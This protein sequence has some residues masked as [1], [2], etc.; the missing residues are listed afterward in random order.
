MLQ[1]VAEKHNW[2]KFISMQGFYNF[3]YREEVRDTI[4]YCKTTEVGLLP[5][6]PLAV[7]MLTHGLE[8]RNEPRERL[9]IF[10]KALIR[11]RGYSLAEVGSA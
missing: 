10:L 11:D 6:S 4:P 3:L 9:D 2:H 5:W 1:N 7:G 8:D